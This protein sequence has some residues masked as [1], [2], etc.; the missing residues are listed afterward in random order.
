MRPSWSRK[1]KCDSPENT[2]CYQSTS[3]ALCSRAHC[4]SRHRWFA[5]RRILYKGTLA[6]NPRCSRRQRIDEVDISIPVAG[7]QRAVNCLKEDV[8]QSPPCAEGVDR[9]ALTSHSVVH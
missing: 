9:H 4:R 6:H 5:V 8:N 2:T 3:Q 7:D 1:L